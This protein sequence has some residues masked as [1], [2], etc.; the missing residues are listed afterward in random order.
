MKKE[1]AKIPVPEERYYT[2]FGYPLTNE[3]LN[4]AGNELLALNSASLNAATTWSPPPKRLQKE[5]RRFEKE[6]RKR[7]RLFRRQ[8][9]KDLS[10]EALKAYDDAIAA[11]E[12]FRVRMALIRGKLQRGK[13]EPDTLELA[14]LAALDLKEH[15]WLIWVAARNKDETF[16]KTLGKCLMGQIKPFALDDIDL[17]IVDIRRKCP[18]IS[19]A[20]MA[21]ELKRRNK[22]LRDCENDYSCLR[23]REK[24]IRDALPPYAQHLF[25]KRKRTQKRP[26]A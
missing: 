23:M 10:P 24:R 21:Q 6:R 22:K 25:P 19:Y 18:S 20:E 2:L 14:K 4:L 26:K 15:R 11:S 17:A 13:L 8:M 5:A 9:W 1:R 12:S 16:F 3:E 7:Q